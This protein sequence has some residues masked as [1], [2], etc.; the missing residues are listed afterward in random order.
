MPKIKNWRKIN[1]S[2]LFL[3]IVA[4]YPS[5]FKKG[6]KSL[7]LSPLGKRRQLGEEED[8]K[9]LCFITDI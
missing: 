8:S 7:K 5:P 4:N 3:N 9:L 2:M 1:K 6:N